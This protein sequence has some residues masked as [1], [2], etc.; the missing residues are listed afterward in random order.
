MDIFERHCELIVNATDLF[1]NT[2]HDIINI[3]KLNCCKALLQISAW[4]DG[5]KNKTHKHVF[6][7]L[8]KI[9]NA[10]NKKKIY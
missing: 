6:A 9:K 2:K 5:E 3:I 7:M 10:F 8:E 4:S 1:F